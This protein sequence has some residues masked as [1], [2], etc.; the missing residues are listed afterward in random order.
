MISGDFLFANTYEKDYN[1]LYMEGVY[2]MGINF[3]AVYVADLIG[4][5][6]MGLLLLTNAWDLPGRK[7]EA[8]ILHLLIVFT[9][10]DCFFDP[11]IFWV[12]GKQGI[13]FRTVNFVGNSFLFLYN[14][15]VGTGVLAIIV[16]HI[17]KKI[18]KIQYRTVVVITIV[19]TA[20][21]VV[22]IFVPV[23]F[24]LDENNVYHREPAYIVYIIAAFYLIMYSLCVY[25][26]GRRRDGSLRFFPVWE[27]L[28]PM[29]IGV[30]IQTCFYGISMQPVCFAVSFSGLVM[31]LQNEYLY[32]DKLTGV[33]NR[34]QLSKIREY[35]IRR[36]EKKMAAIMIDMND[37]KAIND[38]FSHN[39]GDAALVAMAG[40]L[41][42]AVGNDGNVVRFAGDEFVIL[43]NAKEDDVV[44]VTCKKIRAAME[45]YN[46][47]SGK[48]Y[49][50]SAAMGGSVFDL[51]EE[52]DMIG[53]I[54][55][56]MYKDKS[57]YY[58]EHDRRH[59]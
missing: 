58:R 55:A 2:C 57:E 4:I 24:S 16:R 49:R 46:S 20:L 32:V 40:I 9:L 8:K 10:L 59:R 52:G 3:T 47:T 13:L 43:M 48:P 14:L 12:D 23:V 51:N 38:E 7:T 17:N 42:R 54:D 33:Y 36:K 1:L 29:I 26:R 27:F 34:Y 56:L 37:F 11:F 30:V 19:E 21:L 35:Y 25:I 15:I 50:I 44:S 41:M 22:N 39:E 45:D 6:L 31:C 28:M 5:L 53:K 18:S